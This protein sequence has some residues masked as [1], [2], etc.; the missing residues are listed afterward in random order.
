MR[1]WLPVLTL[2]LCATA[3]QAD[4]LADL[5]KPSSTI[6]GC[7][8]D[9]GPLGTGAGVITPTCEGKAA[10]AAWDKQAAMLDA[11]RD[12]LVTESDR[13]L[14]RTDPNI[15]RPRSN[16]LRQARALQSWHRDRTPR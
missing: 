2:L 12:V 1:R 16:G 10:R 8:N 5:S 9:W 7:V 4:S 3:A 13:P 15:R 11:A 14:D 6:P